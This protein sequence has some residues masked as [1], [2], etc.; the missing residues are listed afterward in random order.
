MT[1]VAS[2]FNGWI[3]DADGGT[4]AFRYATTDG[5]SRT[6]GTPAIA[7]DC[8]PAVETAGYYC[9]MPTASALR[10]FRKLN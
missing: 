6:Y 4:R 8:I 10:N 7:T 5:E 3:F 9:L 2:R 1:G